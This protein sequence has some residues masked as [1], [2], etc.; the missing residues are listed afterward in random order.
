MINIQS[1]IDNHVSLKR[2]KSKRQT[3]AKELDPNILNLGLSLAIPE[4]GRWCLPIQYP[5]GG[6]YPKLSPAEL[7]HYHEVCQ[8]IIKTG[9][10]LTYQPKNYPR[11]RA[12]LPVSRTQTQS[13]TNYRAGMQNHYPWISNSNL[14][15][16]FSFAQLLRN[17]DLPQ[18]DLWT[19]Q[20]A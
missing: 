19:L 18:D 4:Q 13:W 15:A 14:Y 17:S 7:D 9:I 6:K 12:I 8:S 16:I 11:Y 5:L 3:G 2:W 10:T 1:F 20:T